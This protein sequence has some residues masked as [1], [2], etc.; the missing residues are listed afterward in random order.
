MSDE[1]A[2]QLYLHRRAFHAVA[3]CGYERQERIVIGL[4][5]RGYSQIMLQYAYDRYD[6][7]ANLVET[8]ADSIAECAPIGPIRPLDPVFAV[9]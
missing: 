6:K 2:L 9:N 3:R 4:A 8:S 5:R 1:Q 7:A